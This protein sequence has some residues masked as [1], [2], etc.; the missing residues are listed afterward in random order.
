MLGGGGGF[1]L[2]DVHSSP[3]IDPLTNTNNRQ[4]IYGPIRFF[5]VFAMIAPYFITLLL[6]ITE[7]VADSLW[8]L[9]EFRRLDGD[10]G[11]SDQAVASRS[12]H[13]YGRRCPND[14]DL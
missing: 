10:P 13:Y 5:Y 14:D 6:G 7:C 11:S 2:G 3:T 1:R 12:R 8:T 9:L 4:F